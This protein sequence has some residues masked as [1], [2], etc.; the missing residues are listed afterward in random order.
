LSGK[1]ILIIIVVFTRTGE[2]QKNHLGLQIAK[3]AK[4]LKK[5][6]LSF[7]EELKENNNREWF[8]KNKHRYEDARKDLCTLVGKLIKRIS[9]FDPSVKGQEVKDC[10]FRIYRD[11]RFSGDKTPYKT[12]LGAAFSKGGKTSF[13][14]GYYIHIEPGNCFLA[15]GVWHPLPPQLNAIRQEI[16]YN[17]EEFRGILKEK[18][19]KKFFS[20]LDKED[21]LKTAPK[22][23]PKDHPAMDLL[24]LKSF[25]VSCKVKDSL[26]LGPESEAHITEVFK[27]M[28]PLNGFLKRA[29][30]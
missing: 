22:G 28:Y 12:H 5:E 27:A 1:L 2:F 4:M 9:A 15:G 19:F 6:T 11:I 14:P 26:L 24:K 30:D 13:E 16:A 23:Y 7:L 25:T 3:Y 17:E 8:E 18:G 21:M 10:V 20:G 29:A